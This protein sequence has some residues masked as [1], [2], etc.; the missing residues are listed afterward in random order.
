[1]M[2]K[3]AES[4]PS[5]IPTESPNT[6]LAASQLSALIDGELDHREIDLV[7]R[8]LNRDADAR[9]CWEHYYL[10]SDT[11]QGHLPEVLDSDFAARIQ[12][13]VEAEPLLPSVSKPFSMWYKPVAGFGVAASVALVAVLGFNPGRIDESPATATAPQPLAATIPVTV[14]PS[15]GISQNLINNQQ[16]AGYKGNLAQSRLN[17]YLVNH[18]G[19]A[20]LNGVNTMLPYVRMVGYQSGR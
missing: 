9:Q 3:T 13:V 15:F 2:F 11:L 1:M 14:P 7:L 16:P 8:R 12:Q 5:S 6:A 18:N 10:I 19:Y 20:S 4:E 17:N